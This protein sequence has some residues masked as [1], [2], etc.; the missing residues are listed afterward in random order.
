MGTNLSVEEYKE[1]I[2]KMNKRSKYGAKKA[3]RDGIKFDSQMERDF[4]DQLVE[5]KKHGLIAGFCRQPSFIL[6]EGNDEDKAITYRPDFIVFHNGQLKTDKTYEIIDVKGYESREW[7][8]T[9]K[10][11]RLKF[12]TLHLEV[13]H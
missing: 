8:R 4:Y 6:M 13:S 2:D 11:F 5:Q 1:L 12:P 3:Y 7:H 9:Y 10:E